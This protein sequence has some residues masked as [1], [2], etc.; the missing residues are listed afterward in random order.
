[1]IMLYLFFGLSYGLVAGFT[2]YVSIARAWPVLAWY[3]KAVLAPLL[4]AFILV[5]IV[6]NWSVA[7][8]IF[9]QIPK[10]KKWTF[11][12]RIDVAKDAK[13]YRGKLAKNICQILNTFQPNHCH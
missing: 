1:M 7:W 4:L 13:G 5:D 11:T 10:G 12:Q 9:F 3:V 8:L 2:A 6:F